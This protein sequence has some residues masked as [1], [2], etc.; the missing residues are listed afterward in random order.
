[1]CGIAGV[2]GGNVPDLDQ[3]LETMLSTIEHRG[4]DDKGTLVVPGIGLGMQRLSI[5]DIADGHQPM[6]SEAGNVIVFNGEIYNYRNLRDELIALGISLSSH[7]DTEVILRGYE[8]WGIKVIDRLVGMFAIALFD[9]K[10]RVLHLVRDRLGK[11]PLYYGPLLQG[12]AFGFA[13]ELKA[14]H[15]LL[16][17]EKAVLNEQSVLDYLAFRFVPGPNTIWKSFRK[18]PPGHRL[19]VNVDSLEIQETQYWKIEVNSN[20][21][22]KTSPSQIQRQFDDLFL[23]AVQIRL[24]ASDVPVGVLL[25]GGLDSSAVVAAAAE[26]GHSALETFSIGFADGGDFSELQYARTVADFL[27]TNHR[28][29]VLTQQEFL[30]LL[31][32][33]VAMSDEPLGDLASIPLFKVCE[34]AARHVKV[35]LTGEGADEVLGG[36]D[37]DKMA[38]LLNRIKMVHKAPKFIRN[39]VAQV[40]KSPRIE[41]VLSGEFRDIPKNQNLFISR[42]WTSQDLKTLW[43][44][45]DSFQFPESRI[46]EWY[47]KATSKNPLDKILQVYLGDWLVEDLLMK[48]DKMSMAN[49]LELRNPFLDHR[50]VEFVAHLPNSYKVGVPFNWTTKRLLRNFAR[51]RIPDVII[52]RPKL[53]F[54]VPAYNWLTSDLFNWASDRLTSNEMLSTFCD[55]DMMSHTVALAKQ[56]DRTA[57]RKTWNLIV[58]DHWLDAWT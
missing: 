27:G 18:L 56:G 15:I 7:S 3:I 45:G 19:V 5:I 32:K 29:V 10:H 30:E 43:M 23:N 2:I 9:A 14:M 57:Q 20:A 44:K 6:I 17:D 42:D 36:Y 22:R 58:L 11:K 31:P 4:P 41:G 24:E 53:G 28:E 38:Q 54:P 52:D 13:S 40:L 21:K 49:S 8:V 46:G 26:L 25:S 48:A 33:F 50:I 51:T 47:D 35:A 34:L 1:V 55:R 16:E 37:F 12:S 39:S